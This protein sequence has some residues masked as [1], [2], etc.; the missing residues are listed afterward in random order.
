MGEGVRREAEGVRREAEGVGGVASLTDLLLETGSDGFGPSDN[1]AVIGCSVR[2]AILQHSHARD[3]LH[4]GRLPAHYDVGPAVVLVRPELRH[5]TAITL[6][7][8]LRGH[9]AG[10]R[11]QLDVK[12]E[13]LG[14]VVD[15]ADVELSV[16]HFRA[17]RLQRDPGL[18]GHLLGLLDVVGF[19][20]QREQGSILWRKRVN[21]ST[22]GQGDGDGDGDGAG[23]GTGASEGDDL[24][25]H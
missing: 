8:R 14:T 13:L 12:L 11:V 9:D 4:I 15:E 5:G 7:A 6:G 22:Y 3:V 16:H 25:K 19:K 17:V 20:E 21:I 23:D 18:V 1:D 10:R 24:G 2:D